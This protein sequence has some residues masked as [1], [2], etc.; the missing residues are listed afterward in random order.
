MLDLAE[1]LFK[2]PRLIIRVRV[3]YVKAET[4]LGEI[5]ARVDSCL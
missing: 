5:M 2:E 4:I 3:N 1:N